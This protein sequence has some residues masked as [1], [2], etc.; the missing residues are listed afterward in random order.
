MVVICNKEEM[1]NKSWNRVLTGR[2][3]E[4]LLDCLEAGLD[5]YREDDDVEACNILNDIIELLNKE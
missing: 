2:G 3:K 5:A 4:I 1:S